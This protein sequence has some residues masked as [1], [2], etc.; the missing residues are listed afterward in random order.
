MS[1]ILFGSNRTES[2]AMMKPRR[3][4][5]LRPAKR[6]NRRFMT[7]LKFHRYRL[8][9]TQ[10]QL[11]RKAGVSQG[12]YCEYERGIKKPL[13]HHHGKLADA[14]GRPIEEVTAKI[15]NVDPA[16]MGYANLAVAR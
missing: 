3:A 10:A 12:L 9:L 14:I 8:R 4:R 6:E 2:A 5:T 7:Y 13:P 11:A 15:H 1:D 16:Q